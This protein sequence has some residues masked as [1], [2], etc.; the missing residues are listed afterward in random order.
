MDNNIKEVI[1]L[2]KIDKRLYDIN[3]RRGDLPAQISQLNKKIE[4]LS[5]TIKEFNSR[6]QI[7][8]KRKVIIEGELSDSDSKVKNLNDQM[9]KVKSN[10]EYE[11]LLKEI[12]HIKGNNDIINNE[13]LE[14]ESE[15]EKINSL[16][17]NNNE[18]LDLLKEKL[19]K[20]ECN[21]KETNLLFEEEEQNLLKDKDKI[22]KDIKHDDALE[23]YDEKKNEYQGLA[24]AEINRGSCENCYSNLP[25]QLVIDALNQTSF[26]NCPTCGI[27]LYQDQE[28]LD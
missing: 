15:L 9:Y 10:K 5:D 18:E 1:N 11:A 20:G 26:V 24:F 22:I 6:V 14:L 25:P 16:I 8:D 12:D 28:N 13:L 4:T 27:L 23:L 3:V 19:D 2:H 7:I 21:L 17:T